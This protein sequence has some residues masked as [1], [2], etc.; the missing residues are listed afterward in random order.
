[1]F[2]V[3]CRL[4]T[5]PPEASRYSS[6]LPQLARALLKTSL[7]TITPKRTEE[8]T[9]GALL[10][11]RPFRELERMM[12]RMDSPF[13]LLEELP[14]I[15][16]EGLVPAVESFVKD[17]N[18]VVRADVPGMDPKDIDV[19]IL[20]NV[21]TVKGE[22]RS[23]QEVKKEDYLRREVSY[24]SFE[25]RMTLPE[26]AAVDKVKATFKNGVLEVTLPM[27]REAVAKKVPV[28]PEAEKKVEIAKK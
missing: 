19:S 22:R 7:K 18:L 16:E 17:G 5:H 21:M 13:R 25:R 8:K 12:R 9:M 27:A 23:E 24:G 14:E 1:M 3:E 6:T 11:W 28:E 15:S 20:G 2:T 10:P 26:G 4:P